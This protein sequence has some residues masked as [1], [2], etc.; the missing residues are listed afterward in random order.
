MGEQAD[1]R[2]C[3]VIRVMLQNHPHG[4]PMKHRL[5]SLVH[6]PWSQLMLATATAASLAIGIPS[7]PAEAL[8]L[9]DLIFRGIQVIQISNL[10][11][12]QEVEIGEQMHRNLISSG[13]LR[14]TNNQYL[15]D[16][17]NYVGQRLV[18]AGSRRNIP[19]T[20]LVSEDPQVNAF[21]TM[22]GR[23]YV[24]TGL[25]QAADNE[26]QFASVVAHEIAHIERR[27]LVKQ[28]RQRM[29]AQGVVAAATGSSRNQLANLGIELA[30]NR[31]H[32][33]SHEYQADQDGLRILRAADYATP[34]MPAFMRKLLNPGTR[35][36]PTFLSTHPAVPDR[37]A[38]LEEQVQSGEQNVCDRTPTLTDCGLN[39]RDYADQVKSQL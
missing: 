21:A 18:A 9:G 16:Y 14:I 26:A 3:K 6:R 39:E 5:T 8:P 38:A 24:T 20:F 31:P 33:R 1:R 32:S 17:V 35:Q 19:Y 15:N 36:T 29:V 7:R 22:G 34:A 13:R 28:I 25:M 30:L 27:H 4:S 2:L 23:V 12:R 10:S 11:D 37:V